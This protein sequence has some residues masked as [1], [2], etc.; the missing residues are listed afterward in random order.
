MYVD[1]ISS[2]FYILNWFYL[3]ILR[4]NIVD[5]CC[6]FKLIWNMVK[7]MLRFTADVLTGKQFVFVVA[8]VEINVIPSF[9]FI[10]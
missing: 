6:L 4:S 10:H 7:I 1:L 3:F 9:S 8:I 5:L 2:I